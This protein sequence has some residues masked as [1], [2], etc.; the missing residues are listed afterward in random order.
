[1]NI[2]EAFRSGWS[3]IVN[4]FGNGIPD[5]WDGVVNFANGVLGGL[6]TYIA[7]WL[8]GL[9]L[10]ITIPDGVFTILNDLTRSIGYLIPVSALLPI[11]IFMLSF[12]VIKLIFAIYQVI[13]STVIQRFKVKL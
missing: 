3:Q 8:S 10:S 6:N 12:Y 2:V 1:M 13:A 11:P 4:W 9:G 7:D 5:L